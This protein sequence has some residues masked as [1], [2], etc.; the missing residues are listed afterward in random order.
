MLRY[1]SPDAEVRKAL[2]DVPRPQLL[3]NYLGQLDAMVSGSSLFAF[4][5]EPI[6]ESRGQENRR[7]HLVDVVARVAGGRL[8]VQWRYSRQFHDTATI[9]A[10]ASRYAETLRELV[11][12]CI[13]QPTINRTPSDFALADLDQASLDQLTSRFPTL[14]DVY[15]LTPMQQLFFS[16]DGVEASPG[17]EQWEFLLEGE[18]DAERLR[19][20]W[21]QVVGRHSILRTAFVQVG[22]ARPHQ[23]VLDRVDMPWHVEDWRA[24][25]ETEQDDRLHEFLAADHRLAFD[26]AAPPLMRIALLRTGETEHRMIWSTHHLLVDGWSWPLIFSELSTLYAGAARPELDPACPYQPIRSVASA[27]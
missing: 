8:S 10:V 2:E 17:F 19:D 9:S 12:H 23:V 4:A 1:L 3:F 26:L 7:S 27:A 15:P 6:G 14:T 21:Q 18:L 11:D 24:C 22:A 5:G 20:A 13:A 16:M 25:T